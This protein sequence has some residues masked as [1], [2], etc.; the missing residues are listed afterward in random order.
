MAHAWEELPYERP[1]DALMRPP[2]RKCARCGTQQT[3]QTQ[4]AWMRVTGRKW[5]PPAGR[6]AADGKAEND[7]NPCATR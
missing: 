2:R 3:L 7:D 5:L 4:Y 1:S 6:C